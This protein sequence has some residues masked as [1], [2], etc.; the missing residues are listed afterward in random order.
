[1][2]RFLETFRDHL[3]RMGAAY[4]VLLLS[5]TPTLIAYRRVRDNVA[6]RDRARFEQ[7]VQSTRNAL[8]QRIETFLSA[9]RGARGLFDAGQAVGPD[10]WQKYARSIDLKG[11]YRGVLDMGFVQRVSREEKERH[12]SAMRA[13][14]FPGGVFSDDLF[15]LRHPVAALG[16]GLGC[17]QRPAKKSRHGARAAG[18]QPNGHGKSAAADLRWSAA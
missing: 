16:P 2:N 10:Q 11:N 4:L 12:V 3:R 15:E 18:G 8:F 14:G 9:L 17:F 1:M 6:A 7:T 13:S 5:V